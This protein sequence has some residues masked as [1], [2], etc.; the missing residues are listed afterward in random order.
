VI[1]GTADK[2]VPVIHG[3]QLAEAIGA[4]TE[5]VPITG[6]DHHLR[7]LDRRGLIESIIAWLLAQDR[8]SQ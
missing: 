8:I 6:G 5:F 7:N 4:A 1:H 2:T 3:K